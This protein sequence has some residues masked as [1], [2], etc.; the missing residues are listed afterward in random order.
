[1]DDVQGLKVFI[2]VAEKLSF[3]R[4]AESLFLTQ[5]AVSRQIL[6][7]EQS[8]GTLLLNRNGRTV[9]L[10]PAG[11]VLI[12]Q[13]RRIFAALADAEAAVRAAGNPDFGRMRIGASATACQFIIPEALREFRESF[14]SYSLTITPGDSPEVLELLLE[15][16]IDLGVLIRTERP[17]KLTYQDLFE[18]ELGFLI[19]PLHPWA[20]KGRVDRQQIQSQRLILYS[21]N[22]A[23]FRLIERYLTRLRLPMQDWIELG[24]MEAIKEMVK[25]GLGISVVARWTA[26]Q[27]ILAKSL[28]WLPLPG[29]KLKRTWSIAWLASR[30]PSMAEHT[31]IRLCEHASMRL[32]P[33]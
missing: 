8:L 4:A 19:S 27:E 9:S 3:T 33:G 11:T 17:S 26:R 16:H 30:E 32:D 15:N 18:D 25:L 2:A 28:V 23:T 20:R 13:S 31:F 10:T 29:A 5:S 12:Q 1:M 24:S 21:R 22:S 14:P 6:R 7:M